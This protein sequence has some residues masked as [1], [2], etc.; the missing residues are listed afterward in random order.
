MTKSQI[1]HALCDEFVLKNIIN[2]INEALF[3][4]QDYVL[5]MYD[6]EISM[7]LSGYIHIDD[8]SKPLSKLTLMKLFQFLASEIDRKFDKYE[9]VEIEYESTEDNLILK[10]KLI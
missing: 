2:D 8:K 7:G 5:S 9:D 4:E 10:V 3:N 1:K 6:H